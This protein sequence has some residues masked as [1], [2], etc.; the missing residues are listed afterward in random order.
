[1][2]VPSMRVRKIRV[3]G[4]SLSVGLPEDWLRYHKLRPGDE[5]EIEYD[6]EVRIRPKP[7]EGEPNAE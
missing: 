3:T 5:V 1:M 7:R 4:G 6:G 2:N